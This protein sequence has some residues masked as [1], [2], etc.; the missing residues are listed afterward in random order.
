MPIT[1]D[2]FE[3]TRKT[4]CVDL[5]SNAPVTLSEEELGTRGWKGNP[6]K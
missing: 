6:K 4:I 3:N 5:C 2:I 1:A